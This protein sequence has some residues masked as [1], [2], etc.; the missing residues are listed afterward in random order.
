MNF[1][2][3]QSTP[4]CCPRI[5]ISSKAKQNSIRMQTEK[6]SH[7]SKKKIKDECEW[8]EGMKMKHKFHKIFHVALSLSNRLPQYTRRNMLEEFISLENRL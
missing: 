1:S 3:N 7:Y 6:K 4:E 2:R 5:A 8:N